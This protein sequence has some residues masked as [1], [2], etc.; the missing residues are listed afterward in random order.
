LVTVGLFLKHFA[1]TTS[2]FTR[3]LVQGGNLAEEPLANT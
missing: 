3:D 2:G 1:L